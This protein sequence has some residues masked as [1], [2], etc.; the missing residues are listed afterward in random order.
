LSI[1]DGIRNSI[2]K[3]G[4][5]NAA[6][7]FDYYGVSPQFIREHA[8]RQ[9]AFERESFSPG[10]QI[11]RSFGLLDAF[12]LRD[13]RVLDIGAGECLLSETLALAMGAKEIVAVD[14]VPKQ[15]WAAAAHHRGCSRLQFLIADVADLP[16]EDASFDIVVGNLILHHILPLGPLLETVRRVLRPGGRFVAMEP[17]LLIESL[18]HQKTSNNEAPIKPKVVID[19]LLSA[20]LTDARATYWWTRMQTDRLGWLSPGY[21]VEAVAPGSGGHSE[22]LLRRPVRETILPGLSIDESCAFSDLVESQASEIR[23]LWSH[24]KRVPGF[25]ATL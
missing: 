5:W 23:D 8:E 14:A 17:T 25:R 18:H 16:F 13:A 15:I 22:T 19:A 3:R 7:E 24:A 2:R 1:V 9:V 4:P 11:V 10:L 12:N 21:R 20:G 6:D